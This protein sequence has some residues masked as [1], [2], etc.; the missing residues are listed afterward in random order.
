M[1]GW[2]ERRELAEKG[3]DDG[4]RMEVDPAGTLRASPTGSCHGEL[5]I[6]YDDSESTET[7][8]E[9]SQSENGGLKGKRDD[10]EIESE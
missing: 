1:V 4:G 2:E 7:K 8:D 10:E 6:E 9:D 5:E 3:N